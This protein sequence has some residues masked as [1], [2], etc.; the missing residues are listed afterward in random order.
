MLE[1]DAVNA[2]VLKQRGRTILRC[3]LKDK[4]LCTKGDGYCLFR[5]SVSNNQTAKKKKLPGLEALTGNVPEN[6]GFGCHV[7]SIRGEPDASN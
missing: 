2:L 3:F 6:L 7:S 1:Y 4:D 5:I